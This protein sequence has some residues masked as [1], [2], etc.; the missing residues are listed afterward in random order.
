LDRLH[1]AAA[2][3]W[4]VESRWYERR[5][6]SLALQLLP[7]ERFRHALEL[8]CSTGV[9]TEALGRRCDRL[10]AMDQSAHAV[11]AARSRLRGSDHVDVRLGTVPDDI[12]AGSFDLVV[13]SEVGYFLS[14]RALDALS[15]R[16]RE[17]LAEDGTL[18]LAHWRHPVSGWPLDGP[19]VHH[20]LLHA[21]LPPLAARYEDRDVE[22]LLLADP[23]QLPDPDS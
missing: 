18:L 23:G 14:P 1:A 9:M 11:R 8:G 7:R 15:D 21:G 3:P 22:I 10:V 13:A 5:K 6:R 2:D 16:L 4:G 17:L 19:R 20:R 12:P